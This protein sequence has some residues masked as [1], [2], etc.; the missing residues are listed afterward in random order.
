M[1][2]RTFTASEWSSNPRHMPSGV[3]TQAAAYQLAGAASVSSV[4]LLCKVPDRATILDYSFYV[5]DAAGS[6]TAN[7]AVNNT[8]QLGLSM[9]EGSG[10]VTTTFSAL[11]RAQTV[12]FAGSVLRP[13]GVNLPLTVSLGDAV[14][15]RWAWITAQASINPSASAL[16]RFTVKYTMDGA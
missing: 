10:S 16:M 15:N 6:A 8:W 13:V 11:S 14:P 5:N 4:Y 7:Q 12:A 3:I 9:Q 1:A 2:A